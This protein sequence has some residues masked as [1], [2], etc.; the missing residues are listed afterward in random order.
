VARLPF[1]ALPQAA[2]ISPGV[3]VNTDAASRPR[4]PTVASE[5]SAKRLRGTAR[6]AQVAPAGVQVPVLDFDKDNPY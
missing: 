6:R 5:A 1:A 2:P 3:A 4:T